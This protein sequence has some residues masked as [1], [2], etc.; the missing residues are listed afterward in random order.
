MLKD[1]TVRRTPSPGILAV[2]SSSRERRCIIVPHVSQQG[3]QVPGDRVGGGE[4]DHP[5]CR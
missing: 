1:A 4:F 3:F 5:Q 2:M